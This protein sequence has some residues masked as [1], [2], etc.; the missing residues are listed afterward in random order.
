M[1][2]HPYKMYSSFLPSFLVI[3]LENTPLPS[4]LSAKSQLEATSY[5]VPAYKRRLIR[6]KSLLV[7]P[8]L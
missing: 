5:L 6:Q 8:T 4:F 7:E 3:S 2:D 1:C